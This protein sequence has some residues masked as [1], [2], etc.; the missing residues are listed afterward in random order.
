MV[1]YSTQSMCH[2]TAHANPKYG[3]ITAFIGIIYLIRGVFSLNGQGM[4]LSQ[5]NNQ[6][7]MSARTLLVHALYERTP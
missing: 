6:H 1:W 3:I 4:R 5:I 2:K 7:S